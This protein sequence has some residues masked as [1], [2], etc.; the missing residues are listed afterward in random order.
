MN[1]LLLNVV[2]EKSKYVF[3]F[4]NW[5][6]ISKKITKFR[7]LLKVGGFLYYANNSLNKLGLVFVM[8]YG[9]ELRM[10]L[11]QIFIGPY[12]NFAFSVNANQLWGNIK[13]PS[14]LEYHTKSLERTSKNVYTFLDRYVHNLIQSNGYS[15]NIDS[16]AVESRTNI[17][18][19][20][21][22]EIACSDYRWKA[23]PPL[24]GFIIGSILS[25]TIEE[26]IIFF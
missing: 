2:C 22:F 9:R 1:P 14:L 19:G 4:D 12:L 25:R 7:I 10:I 6:P 24:K 3:E 17:P 5:K 13:V 11:R 18:F 23:F 21:L 16:R 26:K 15:L 20:D 8:V